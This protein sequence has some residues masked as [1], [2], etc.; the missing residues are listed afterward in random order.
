MGGVVASQALDKYKDTPLTKATY[1]DHLPVFRALLRANA[2]LEAAD[3]HGRTPLMEA[4]KQGRL[5]FVLALLGAGDAG[6]DGGDSDGG[7]GGKGA[8]HGGG[9]FRREYFKE[10]ERK[11]L[12]PPP[13]TGILKGAGESLQRA[14]LEEER[15]QK[16]EGEGKVSA[17]LVFEKGVGAC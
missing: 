1:G 7:R 10:V 11:K 2:Q 9:N 12:L 15:L 6:D 16:A 3:R 13:P 5:P 14:Q 4:C 17:K 8:R